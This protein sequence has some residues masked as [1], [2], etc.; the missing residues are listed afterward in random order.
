MKTAQ[1]V[2]SKTKAVKKTGQYE[3]VDAFRKAKLNEVINE[4]KNVNWQGVLS[5]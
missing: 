4:T 1:P 2:R 3:S 5:K